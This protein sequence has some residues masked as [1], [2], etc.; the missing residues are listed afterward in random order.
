[1]EE[2]RTYLPNSNDEHYGNIVK[3]LL[4][5]VVSTAV[6]YLAS[7]LLLP[8]AMG[9]ML[10]IIFSPV[11]NRLDHFVG[12]FI[13]AAMVVVGAVAMAAA[14]G[15]FLTIELT[16]VAMQVS[17]YSTNIGTKLAAIE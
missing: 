5:I 11:A 3:P 10:A 1:M 12:R 16:S 7:G 8:V 14:V 2:L 4:G 17:D 15:Y 9:A 13:S 6:L